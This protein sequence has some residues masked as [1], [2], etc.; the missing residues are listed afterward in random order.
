MSQI[1]QDSFLASP[2]LLLVDSCR[3]DGLSKNSDSLWSLGSQ[4]NFSERT[5]GFW[6]TFFFP[7]QSGIQRAGSFKGPPCSPETGIKGED[8]SRRVE[9]KMEIE[10]I[11]LH[12]LKLESQRLT[13]GSDKSAVSVSKS[14]SPTTSPQSAFD[15]GR[16]IVLVPTFRETEVDSYFSAFK[17]IATA[18][19]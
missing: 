16:N 17:D 2:S 11:Q 4:T 3:K 14:S 8:S 5:K 18:L 10:A 19:Q 1:N 15:V 9:K 13:Q 7:Q 6:P 12:K